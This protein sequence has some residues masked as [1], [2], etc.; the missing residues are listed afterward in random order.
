MRCRKFGISLNTSKSIFDVTRSKLLGHIF[1]DSGISIDHER[2]VAIL[3]LPAPT[4]KKEVQSFM[5]VINFVRR[6][7]L[8]F[9]VMVK[10]IHNLLK[11]D[12]SFSWTDDI[13]NAFV[14]IKKAINSAPIL[15]K[16]DFEKEFMIYTNA[17]EEVVSAILMQGDDQGNEKPVAYMSQILSDYEFKYYFI[18]KHAFSLVKAVEKFHYFILGKHTLVK[19]PLPAVKFSL[20]L[21]YLSGKIAHWLAKIQEDDLTIVTSTTIKGCDLAFHLAQHVETSEEIDEHDSSL[22]TLFYIDNQ[23]LPVSEHPW[24]K[25]LVYYLQDQRCPDNL[26]THQRRS[27]H[28]QSARYVIIGDFLFRITTDGMLVRCV[29][30]EE[31]QK[32][33][34]ETHGS[35]DSVIH[36][37]GHF[38]A[39]T[40]A[41]K[42]IRK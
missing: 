32:L 17:T 11:Q 15:A 39:K 10:P 41:F 30:N 35:S 34:Q 13:K 5:G 1:S 26:D 19:V 7:V 3:N 6:F 12:C 23:I 37:G 28:L 9:V 40:T 16:L 33:L 36:V 14:G 18:E 2:I 42:I 31:T 27:L 25:N 29:N 22:S 4:S 21:T 38:S 20:S 8:D 24:Y